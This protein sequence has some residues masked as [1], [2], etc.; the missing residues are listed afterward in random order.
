[1]CG[2]FVYL[3]VLKKLCDGGR[4]H[5]NTKYNFNAYDTVIALVLTQYLKERDYHEELGRV[6]S[7]KEINGPELADLLNRAAVWAST[8]LMESFEPMQK[9][10]ADV[11]KAALQDFSGEQYVQSM[12][13]GFAEFLDDFLNDD[14]SPQDSLR[15]DSPRQ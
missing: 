12:D 9:G 5:M 15:Q 11:V 8:T 2:F 10:L 6:I 4:K 1:M 7:G 3:L 14:I 13:A